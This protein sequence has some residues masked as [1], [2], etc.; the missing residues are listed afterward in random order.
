MINAIVGLML[1]SVLVLSATRDNAANV[2][3]NC[4]PPTTFNVSSTF[5]R[6]WWTKPSVVPYNVVLV[7]KTAG[8][9]PGAY[10]PEGRHSVMYKARQIDG[11]L[12]TCQLVF[13]VH[14]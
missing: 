13:T 11:S 8:F 4:P 5:T 1:L 10:F 6:I 12:S 3:I 7:W 9:L 14:V 2:F